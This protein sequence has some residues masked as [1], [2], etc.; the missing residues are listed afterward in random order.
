MECQTTTSGTAE[1]KQMDIVV[2]GESRRVPDPVTVAALLAWL[3]LDPSRVAVELDGR[4]ARQ[5]EWA[6]TPI[7]RGACLE[8]V[9]FVGGG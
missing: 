8:I 7:P 6:D 3:E 9:Q 1:T 5:S 2:N 4:I